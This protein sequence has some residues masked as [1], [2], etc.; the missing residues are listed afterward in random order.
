MRHLDDE[1]GD[2]WTRS[3]V[4]DFVQDGYDKICREAECLFD[5]TMFDR[6]PYAGN[7]TR[8]FERE[9]MTDIPI[10]EQFNFTKDSDQEYLTE[11]TPYPM[12]GPANHTRD[13]EA[14]YFT[15]ASEPASTT[16]TWKL[17]ETFVSVARVTHDWLRLL[18][19]SARYLR[20]SR[21]IYPTEQGGV[22]S[23]SMDQDGLFN[24]RT[25][26]VPTRTI[27]PETISGT[28]GP[29][30]AVTGTTY[31]YDDETV[32]ANN[33]GFG[34]MR[35]VPQHFM[36][37][38]QEYGGFR[39]ITPDSNA[40]RVEFYRLGQDL[41]KHPF[42]V[43]DRVVKYCEWWALHRAYSTPGEGEDKALAEHYKMRYEMGRDRIKAR[44]NN[45][46]KEHTRGM[47]RRRLGRL[48]SYLERFPSSYGYSRPFR[49]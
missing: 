29:I 45:I 32:I 34:I 39:R 3:Q 7:Y 47:G 9:Y 6:T 2:V 46:M 4:E 18:P 8:P 33:G 11:G 48:D 43:P 5:M 1:S 27:E 41:K 36:T 24:F 44:A 16:R 17:P 26:G 49:G 37:S 42:E 19:E 12:P 25:V 23:Y 22:F 14:Q 38:S 20:K 40:T 30:R 35:S 21:N 13:V 10:L 31:D 28:Y 15:T